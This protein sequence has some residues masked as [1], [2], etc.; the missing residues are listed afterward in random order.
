MT[1]LQSDAEKPLRPRRAARP[2]P[3]PLLLHRGRRR[4]GGPSSAEVDLGRGRHHRRHRA[5]PR[6]PGLPE[7][8]QA[9]AR[10]GLRLPRLDTG[11]RPRDDDE[12]R[13][14]GDHGEDRRAAGGAAPVPGRAERRPDGLAAR[15]AA[16]ERLPDERRQHPARRRD[17]G[18]PDLHRAARPR[19]PRLRVRLPDG[20]RADAT[21][22]HPKPARP[23][24]S[25]GCRTRI[26]TAAKRRPPRSRSARAS[27]PACRCG[28]SAR[29]RTR[30]TSAYQDPRR[31]TITLPPTERFG[32]NRDVVLR[33]RLADDRIETGLLLGEER[34]RALLRC[35]WSSRR[36]DSTPPGAT[37]RVR[38]RHG[39]LRVDERV[40]DR[41]VEGAAAHPARQAQADRLVQRHLLLRRL[42]RPLAVLGPGDRR[43]QGVGDPGNRPSAWRRRHRAAA[44]ASPGVRPRPDPAGHLARRRRG[45]RRLRER[46]ARGLHA[47]P[48]TPLRRQPVRLRD[49]QLSQPAP[50]RRHGAGRRGRAVRR[51][52]RRRGAAGRRQVP[53]LH[54]IAAADPRAHRDPRL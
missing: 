50:D 19:E 37:A 16:P 18:G 5:S 52:Q 51:A 46:R 24:P 32:A 13:R 20:R 54:R 53:A 17:Q 34:R 7:R 42:L 29:R 9:A 38:L 10:G 4:V 39:R 36:G 23:T 33:Y 2:D 14:P 28:K 44:G 45:H 43:Q 31:A 35:A 47:H 15:A 27:S 41:D 22:P 25:A 30:S 48:R 49:R 12:D 3:V 8:R 1:K 6:H 40:S 26:S 11:R 21:R